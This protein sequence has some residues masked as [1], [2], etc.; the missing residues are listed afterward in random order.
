MKRY[1]HN[2]DEYHIYIKT[3]SNINFYKNIGFTKQR[4]LENYIRRCPAKPPLPSFLH[5]YYKTS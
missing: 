3:C 1:T 4:R 2:K 5:A